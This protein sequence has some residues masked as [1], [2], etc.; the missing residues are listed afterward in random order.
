MSKE[1]ALT[2][3]LG[4]SLSALSAAIADF[5]GV[6]ITLLVWALIGSS[7]AVFFVQELK[8]WQ[9]I[10]R[11]LVSTLVGA[12]AIPVVLVS[13]GW[14]KSD[15]GHRFIALLCGA[16]TLIV[17]QQVIQRAPQLLAWLVDI[18]RDWLRK[19]SGL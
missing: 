2:T 9:A 3:V 18:G 6:P 13:L 4:A 10:W 19:R 14:E 7:V 8:R 16:L 1:A 5:A 17:L 11:V 15:W 12:V